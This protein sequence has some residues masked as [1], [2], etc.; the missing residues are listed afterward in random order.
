VIIK[1]L[2]GTALISQALYRTTPIELVELMVQL[3]ELLEKSF[4]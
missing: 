3:E 4:I 1:V 2:L